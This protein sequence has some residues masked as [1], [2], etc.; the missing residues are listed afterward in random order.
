MP[1]PTCS[2]LLGIHTVPDDRAAVPP[3]RSLFSISSTRQPRSAPTRAA[4]S[5]PMPAPITTR[6]KSCAPGAV[7]LAMV[8]PLSLRGERPRQRAPGI[9]GDRFE[10]SDELT[11]ARAQDFVEERLRHVQPLQA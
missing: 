7:P 2:G 9:E 10:R 4:V 6:S 8:K 1:L 5:P 11:P 3:I